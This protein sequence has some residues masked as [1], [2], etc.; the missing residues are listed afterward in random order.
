MDVG[1]RG[2][3]A[4]REKSG[5]TRRST[6]IYSQLKSCASSEVAAMIEVLLRHSLDADIDTSYVDTHG[7]SVVG[8]AF[9]GPLGFRLLPRLKN[10]GAIRPYR[11]DGTGTSY[12]SPGR[13]STPPRCAWVPR[14]PRPSC[15]GS[16][17]RGP[18]TA[19]MSRWR[20]S[21]A[22][23]EIHG[24]LQVVENWNSGNPVIFY[25]KDCDLTGPIA[26]TSRFPCSPCTTPVR[27]GACQHA[28]TSWTPIRVL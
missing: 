7:A 11:L 6:C 22:R 21:G 28:S 15:G 3:S 12:A 5:A 18:N 17:A 20:S 26:S 27:P 25:S 24:G 4:D 8:F 13:S 16:P 2:L 10:L 14:S 1:R 19:R 23:S 9:T